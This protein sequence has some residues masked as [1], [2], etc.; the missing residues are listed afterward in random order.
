M[1]SDDGIPVDFVIGYAELLGEISAT[2][3]LPRRAEL[4]ALAARVTRCSRRWPR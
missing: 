4:D 2:G 3:R 1:Q